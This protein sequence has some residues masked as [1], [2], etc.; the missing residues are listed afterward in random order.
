MNILQFEKMRSFCIIVAATQKDRGIGYKN[1]IP[2]KLK[3][4]M[5]EFKSI[6]LDAK[7][8][9]QNA[10]VMGR[11]T[12]ESI[13][14]KFRPLQGRFNI[15]LTRDTSGKCETSGAVQAN[16][17]KEAFKLLP[18]DIDQIFIAGGA[19]LYAEALQSPYCEQVYVTTIF[20]DYLCDTF[21]PILDLSKFELKTAGSIQQQDDVHFQFTHY[22]KRHEEHQYLDLIESCITTGN[23]KS[24]RTGIDT[25]S[26]FGR[27]MRFSLR[28]GVFPLLTTKTV[29]W[30]GVVEELL[31]LIKGSTDSKQLS[32]KR[33]KIWDG[34]GSRDF[35]DKNGF[36]QREIGDLGPL[37]GHVCIFSA[38]FFLMLLSVVIFV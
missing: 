23:I 7:D 10:V 14:K 27:T 34:N 31:W 1:T 32:A 36:E 13:P 28:D 20:K 8:D 33:V 16:S 4:D 35:L 17:L 19:A 6:T 3:Q 18:D 2:W 5:Q 30:R 37:Y 9:M 25:H 15:V 24:N 21:F 11:K 26:H 22:I 29:F 12:W 38:H